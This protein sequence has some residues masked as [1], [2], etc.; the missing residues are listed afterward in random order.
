MQIFGMGG[1][2]MGLV[3]I[4]L[5]INLQMGQMHCSVQGRT[6]NSCPGQ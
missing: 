2:D 1:V 3:V 6:D 4:W 5:E